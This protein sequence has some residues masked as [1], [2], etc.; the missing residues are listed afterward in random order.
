MKRWRGSLT[1]VILIL[2]VWVSNNGNSVGKHVPSLKAR[3]V[4]GLDME[5]GLGTGLGTGL[6]TT[7]K[8]VNHVQ[9]RMGEGRG[10]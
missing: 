8:L 7:K 9:V 1:V 2:K 3:C 4:Q 5:E 6:Q 10:V